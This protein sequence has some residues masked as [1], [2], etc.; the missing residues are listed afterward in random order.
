MP[1]QTSVLKAIHRDQLMNYS[2]VILRIIRDLYISY[3]NSYL[4]TLGKIPVP[5]WQV[6]SYY[7]SWV[8]YHLNCLHNVRLCILPVLKRRFVN[9]EMF[10]AGMLAYSEMVYVHLD[11]FVYKILVI[12]RSQRQLILKH[13]LA[14]TC[15]S[16]GSWAHFLVHARLC[17]VLNAGI[18]G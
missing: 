7:C 6:Y 18:P 17:W 2:L 5:W 10:S 3:M 8:V 16:L 4:S 1:G 14:C 12:V 13:T 9:S 15:N 11:W